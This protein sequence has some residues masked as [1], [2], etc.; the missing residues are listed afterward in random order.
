MLIL[1]CFAFA[2]FAIQTTTAQ[3]IVIKVKD[4]TPVENGGETRVLL[5]DE[6][7]NGT[8]TCVE[9]VFATEKEALKA[10]KEGDTEAG[11]TVQKTRLD[12]AKSAVLENGDGSVIPRFPVKIQYARYNGPKTKKARAFGEP[13]FGYSR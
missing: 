6:A 2:M 7:E 11:K 13:I 10:L 3:T 4:A 1:S 9:K 12:A 8:M 5:M